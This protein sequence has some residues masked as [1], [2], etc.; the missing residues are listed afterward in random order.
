MCLCLLFAFTRVDLCA[1]FMHI[2]IC[3]KWNKSAM[4]LQE[5]PEPLVHLQLFGSHQPEERDGLWV[6]EALIV[7][8]FLPEKEQ[9]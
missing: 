2:Y 4:R 1:H 7:W 3:I 5:A 6:L 8:M 9:G